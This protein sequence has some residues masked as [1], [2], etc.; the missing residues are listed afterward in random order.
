MKCRNL[1]EKAEQGMLSCME[2]ELLLRMDVKIN[3]KGT[4]NREATEAGKNQETGE[5]GC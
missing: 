4:L 3:V 1:S 5:G 2:V